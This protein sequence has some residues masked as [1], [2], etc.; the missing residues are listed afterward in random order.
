[1]QD[2]EI[3][4]LNAKKDQEFRLNGNFL[5]ATKVRFWWQW[6]FCNRYEKTIRY[7]K[8]SKLTP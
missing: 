6:L 3:E 2:T 8:Q 1:M 7:K 4:I 5:H